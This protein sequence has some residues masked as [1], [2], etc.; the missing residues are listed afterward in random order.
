MSAERIQEP[1]RRYTARDYYA[2]P[3][4]IRV[5]L[6]DG[7]FYNMA[8]PSRAHQRILMELAYMIQR[9]IRTNNGKCE[10]YPA[11][12]SVKLKK[13]RSDI[14]EPDIT[15]ICD[16]SKLTKRGCEGAPDWIIE[17]V[18]PS[19][20][21]H[22]YITK[23]NLYHEAGVRE[24]WIVDPSV[25][26]VHVYRLEKKNFDVEVFSFRDMISVGIYKNLTINFAEIDDLL[27]E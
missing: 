24:Y 7:Q 4:G 18:S 15:V 25:K 16:K 26:R 3:E 1:E 9:Y 27:E 22:D 11:P 23:L 20:P 13:R 14:V 10:V 19:D 21:G 8:S 17:I 12:F 2:T 5:E 6:I